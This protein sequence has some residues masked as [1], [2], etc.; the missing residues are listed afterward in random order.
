MACLFHNRK[1][2]WASVFHE[3]ITKQV[4]GKLKIPTSVSCYLVHLYKCQNL[5]TQDELESY[6]SYQ[7]AVEMD[8][9]E[10]RSATHSEKEFDEEP[11]VM[12]VSGPVTKRKAQDPAKGKVMY[13]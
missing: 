4:N 12:E 10:Q 9:P 7:E 5:L 8:N 1:T 13:R 11:E 2:N 3:V 6:E